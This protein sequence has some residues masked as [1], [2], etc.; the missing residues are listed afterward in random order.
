M[1]HHAFL[2]KLQRQML[3]QRL[4]EPIEHTLTSLMGERVC[5]KCHRSSTT[6]S[7][8]PENTDAGAFSARF[9]F[10]K[11][12]NISRFTAT[13]AMMTHYHFSSPK[14]EQSLLFRSRNTHPLT[15]VV[16]THP[17]RL[18]GFSGP[19]ALHEAHG[20]RWDTGCDW[21]GSG[22]LPKPLKEPLEWWMH[23]K[24]KTKHSPKTATYQKREQPLILFV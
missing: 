19:N 13:G 5:T 21:S 10:E 4:I 14:E 8:P 1:L 9:Y 20:L 12:P 18:E 23:Q 6:R 7:P 24:N 16:V 22:K 17:F 15:V 2:S 11:L 3:C